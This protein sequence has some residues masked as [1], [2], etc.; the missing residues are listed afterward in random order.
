MLNVV[1]VVGVGVNMFGD[2][3]SVQTTYSHCELD[4][5]A[6]RK[7]I[8]AEVDEMSVTVSALGASQSGEQS[9]HSIQRIHSVPFALER[10]LSL[11]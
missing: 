11:M 8:V 2:I 6:G 1:S 3:P 9:T 5:A 4:G 7:V 10:E